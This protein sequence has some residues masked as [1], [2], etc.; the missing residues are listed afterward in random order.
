MAEILIK[1][2][3]NGPTGEADLYFHADQQKF[4]DLA[5]TDSAGESPTEELPS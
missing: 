1:K 5:K 2:H 4:T 3:R